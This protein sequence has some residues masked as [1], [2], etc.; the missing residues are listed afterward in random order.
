VYL[1]ESPMRGLDI[2]RYESN[3]LAPRFIG[4]FKI[5]KE[6]EEENKIEFLSFFF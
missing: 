2:S 5:K 3:K 4:L 6:R 1:N